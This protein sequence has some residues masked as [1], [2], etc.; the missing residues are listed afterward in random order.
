[1]DN[2]SKK[3]VDLISTSVIPREFQCVFPYPEFNAIQSLMFPR[4]MDTNTNVM[5]SAPTGCGKTVVAELAIVNSILKSETP[6]LMLYV[7]PLRALCQ[8]KVRTWTDRFGRC[9]VT[10]QEY[11]G[12]S[13]N[14]LPTSLHSNMLLCTTPEKFDLATR[15][16]KRKTDIFSHISLVIID[17]VH[18]LGDNRGAVLEAM[19]TRLLMISDNNEINFGTKP[20]R[21]IALSATVPNYQDIAKWIRAENPEETTFNDSFRST[22]IETHVFGYRTTSND[23]QFE[24]SLTNRVST[25]I[26]QFSNGKPTLIF[27]CTRK[28]CEKTATKIALDIPSLPKVINPQ[29]H[30]KSLSSLLQKGV[31]IHTAGLAQ[32]DRELVED[33]FKRGAIKIICATST[34][35]QGINLPAALVIIKGTRHYSDGFL[36]DYDA[37]QILQMMGRAGRPQFHDSGIC[38]IMTEANKSKQYEMIA[39]NS[40]PVESVLLSNL[41][42]HVNAEI[43]LGTIH[44]LDDALKWLKTT[45][46]YIRV[47]QNPLYYHVHNLLGV[48]NF[49]ISNIKETIGK[50]ENWGFITIDDSLISI[51]PVGALCS[52][53]G[54]NVG[55]MQKFT[56]AISNKT[57][58]I[59]MEDILNLLSEADEFNDIIV[60]QEDRQKMRIIAADQS[61]HYQPVPCDDPRFFTSQT[62]VFLIIQN[63]LSQ[64]KIEDWTLSQEFTKIKRIADRLL[65]ALYNLFVENKIYSGAKNTFTL[66]KCIEKQ[67]WETERGRIAQQVKGIG[68]VYA[69]KLSAAGYDSFPLLKKA[70]CHQLERI[71]GHRPGWGI[72]I[73]DNIARVPEYDLT[74]YQEDPSKSFSSQNST[75]QNTLKVILT[76]NSTQDPPI[77]HHGCE[78]LIGYQD[79]ILQSYHMRTN[80]HMTSTYIVKLENEEDPKEVEATVLD[81]E[82]IGVDITTKLGEKKIHQ[83]VLLQPATI[84][85]GQKRVSIVPEPEE[86]VIWEM[87]PSIHSQS[88]QDTVTSLENE[89]RYDSYLEE[90]KENEEQNGEKEPLQNKSFLSDDESYY[91]D[92]LENL[93][94]DDNI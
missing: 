31:G 44:S 89:T 23:W 12:D 81:S 79:Q 1:M 70:Q 22:P 56:K 50:L 92:I 43:A 40:R 17:E 57:K 8:E 49:L 9:G 34:L 58:P 19:V 68:E 48:E 33:L 14:Q 62:K 54:L 52:K 61:N 18:T 42:E 69:R 37:S 2:S 63:A 11:T 80:A 41:I 32:D 78:L 25:L 75:D 77:G 65:S 55:T 93:E 83:N 6:S 5:L 47:P 60:R 59:T 91:D 72:A 87:K 24:S 45:F 28:S 84:P 74:I 15:S 13:N 76:N 20:I 35:S 86:V 27:C 82:F 94:F 36:H 85:T 3:S 90:I 30:D 73:S 64:G 21:I 4:I 46:F 51:T 67:M 39:N 38:V 29:C 88:T 7:S 53:Y 10:V 26:N 66:K 71:T 16:W